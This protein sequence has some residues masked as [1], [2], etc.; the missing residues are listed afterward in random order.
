MDVCDDPPLGAKFFGTSKL[1]NTYSSAELALGVICSSLLTM[2]QF[3]RHVGPK[4]ASKLSS[5]RKNDSSRGG[6]GPV[7]RNPNRPIPQWHDM[8]DTN[9]T[10]TDR[11][12]NYL[13]LN[14]SVDWQSPKTTIQGGKDAQRPNTMGN[15]INRYDA[16]EETALEAGIMK[17]VR[18]EQ[19]PNSVKQ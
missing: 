18:V 1:T 4:I 16:S 9:T 8:F 14:D 17:T 5:S 10:I 11:T 7:P 3:Y 12:E 13:E 19:F 6:N 2:P 15:Y